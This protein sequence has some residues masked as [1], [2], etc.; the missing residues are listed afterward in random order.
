[1]AKKPYIQLNIEHQIA[2]RVKSLRIAAG[3]SSY[4][5]FAIQND[6]DRKQYW[7]I[8]KGCNLTLRS[9]VVIANCHKITLE[10]F[11]KEL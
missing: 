4:E 9:I 7:R 3:Y 8:E 2:H 10:D 6:I 5:T 11:F 1:M